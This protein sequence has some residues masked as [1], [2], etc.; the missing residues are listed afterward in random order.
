MAFLFG[1]KKKEAPAPKVGDSIQAL[2]NAC[3][4]LEKRQ[5]YLST[6]SA[7][8]LEEARACMKRKDKLGAT[9]KLKLKKMKEQEI[10]QSYGKIQ[11]LEMQVAALEQ[12]V[13]GG[14]VMQAM[15]AG[16]HG[17]KAVM[18]EQKVEEMEE[19]MDDI[20]ESMSEVTEAS[21]AMARPIGQQF[22][23]VCIVILPEFCSGHGQFDILPFLFFHQH[24]PTMLISLFPVRARRRTCCARG[25]SRR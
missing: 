12:A 17:I 1:T 5:Q 25:R 22:D 10:Q 4:M 13:V 21:E 9:H 6:Q 11:N 15:K 23:E 16:H 2:R 19:L 8:L 14:Q 3:G 7:A 20:T 24:R 18:A